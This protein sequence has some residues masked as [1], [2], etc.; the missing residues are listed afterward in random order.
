MIIGLTGGIASG[1]ST[2]ASMFK[3]LGCVIIDA[4]KV[5]RDVVK[6]GQEGLE[7]VV[8][9]FGPQILT[10]EGELDRKALGAI[11]FHNEEKRKELNSIL[12]PLIRKQM[13]REKEEAL[14]A[15]PPLIIM[16]IPLLFESQLEQTVE[17]V[18][19]VYVPPNQ[20]LE[21]LM[22]RDQISREE[23]RR[24]M[25]SQMPID[26]KKKRADFIIENSGSL[27]ETRTQVEAI[28][29]KLSKE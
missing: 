21:R 7:A 5:A 17:A 6:P 15:N 28:F 13:Q 4:D 1:K 2:V 29:T 23:A 3:E 16:D 9:R 19:V 27:A 24:K 22:Q 25:D 11:I 26:E 14:Q 20:Q 18:I 10:Q 12:H 8:H